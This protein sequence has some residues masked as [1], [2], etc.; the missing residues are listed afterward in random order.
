DPEALSPGDRIAFDPERGR[1]WV[2]CP[3]C[4]RWNATPLE[5]RWELL[6]ACE[7]LAA[8]SGRVRLRTERLALLEVGEGEMVRVGPAPR[9]ELA[10]WRYGDAL[11]AP[12][13]RGFWARLFAGLPDA[14]AGGYDY[15]GTPL[16][17]PGTWLL[18]RFH[19]HAAALTRAFLT[20]P[21]TAVCPSCGGVM[22]LDPR[23][24]EAL[25]LTRA[26]GEPAVAATCA[27]CS[28]TGVV[29]LSEGCSGSEAPGHASS[30]TRAPLLAHAE[31]LEAHTEPRS[32]LSRGAAESAE[33]VPGRA[34][35]GATPSLPRPDP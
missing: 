2:V 9:S 4:G 26:A 33:S 29:A 10:P 35:Y 6:E 14:P 27:A 3:A 31:P 24:F 21:F 30:L 23:D 7:R 13:R 8:D 17:T 11:P 25:R 15:H 20:V 22:P 12:G 5:A 28:D 1:F 34:A 16:P 19:E 32:F 18:S